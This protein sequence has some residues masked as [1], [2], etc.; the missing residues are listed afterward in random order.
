MEN[1]IKLTK[2][3]WFLVTVVVVMVVMVKANKGERRER[4]DRVLIGRP[5]FGVHRVH[6]NV[7][8]GEGAKRFEER[9]SKR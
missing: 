8:T 5:L 1:P 7:E 3:F 2:V 4:E 9:D 6:V